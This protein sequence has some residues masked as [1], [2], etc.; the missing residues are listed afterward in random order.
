MELGQATQSCQRAAIEWGLKFGSKN[1]IPR[2]NLITFKCS[3][4]FNYFSQHALSS[5]PSGARAVPLCACA[6]PEEHADLRQ[7]GGTKPSFIR[8]A[9]DKGPLL[10]PRASRDLGLA[11]E[12]RGKAANAVS[13]PCLHGAEQGRFRA[14]RRP[15]TARHR[16]SHRELLAPL[17]EQQNCSRGF[18]SCSE[19]CSRSAVITSPR[20]SLFDKHVIYDG[21]K[22]GMLL[23]LSL[24]SLS[25]DSVRFCR[26]LPALRRL[27]TFL[28]PTT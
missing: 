21:I 24:L 16:Q 5:P 14:P 7:A 3:F 9:P 19:T 10:L 20:C 25:D 28:K 26:H 12:A 11:R 22:K 6:W 4:V 27:S 8:M 13:R 1:L 17:L 23:M 15:L 18:A 2:S